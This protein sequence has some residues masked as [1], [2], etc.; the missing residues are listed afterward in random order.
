MGTRL[1]PPASTLVSSPRSRKR[2][3]A[4]DSVLGAW[5]SNGAGFIVSLRPW[6]REQ[7]GDVLPD[8]NDIASPVSS[9]RQH[10]AWLDHRLGREHPVNLA[11]SVHVTTASGDRRC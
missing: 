2:D 11:D 8:E 6:R 1:W 7:L 4:S 10:H 9:D 3:T 5:Y